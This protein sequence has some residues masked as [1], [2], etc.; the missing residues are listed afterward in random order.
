MNLNHEIR[1]LEEFSVLTGRAVDDLMLTD[2]LSGGVDVVG[3]V[4]GH[5][6]WSERI[7]DRLG[8]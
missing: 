3:V 8:E 4:E 5:I 1:I 2:A 6:N 7:T